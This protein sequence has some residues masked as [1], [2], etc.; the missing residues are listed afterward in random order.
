MLQEQ[1]NVLEQQ[2]QKWKDRMSR[3]EELQK[4][5]QNVSNTALNN[6]E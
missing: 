5:D 3:F 6:L 2:T 1:K 4:N